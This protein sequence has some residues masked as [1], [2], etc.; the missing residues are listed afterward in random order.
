MLLAV[1]VS[2][3]LICV[4]HNV[5][6]VFCEVREALRENNIAQCEESLNIAVILIVE[7]RL[8]VAAPD[9]SSEVYGIEF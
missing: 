8:R 6:F 7:Y 3:I 1:C 9:G 2:H 4:T 5:G